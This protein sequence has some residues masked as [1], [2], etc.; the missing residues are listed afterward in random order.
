MIRNY[1]LIKRFLLFIFSHRVKFYLCS[2]NY[3]VY[4]KTLARK[5]CIRFVYSLLTGAVFICHLRQRNTHTLRQSD[6]NV[7]AR[8]LSTDQPGVNNSP[9]LFRYSDYGK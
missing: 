5:N 1:L 2:L 8:I 9:E 6:W 7:V 3:N 4:N